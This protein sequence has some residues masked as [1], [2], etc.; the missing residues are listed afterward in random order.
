MCQDEEGTSMFVLLDGV[1]EVIK[2]GEKV[3]ELKADRSK[4][5]CP[6]IGEMA[7]LN[8]SPRSATVTVTSEKARAL[9][10]DRE[11]F[12]FLLGSLETILT[13]D[14]GAARE[15]LVGKFGSKN[16]V[17]LSNSIQRGVIRHEDLQSIGLLGCGHTG[18]V[19]LV[20]HKKTKETYALKGLSKGHMC[21]MGSQHRVINERDILLLAD[22]NFIIRCYE[23]YNSPQRL[24]F[25]LEP[26]M[27]GDLHTQYCSLGA[28]EFG[29]AYAAKYY[30]AAV[31]LAFEH[32]HQRKVIYRDL[33]LENLL[34][35][36]KGHLK[37]ADFD[38]SKIVAT[39]KTWTT[40]GT[41]DYF[42]PEMVQAKGHT[43][44][45]DWWTLG[46]LIFEL[47]CGSTPFEAD[48][49]L[50]IFENV[51]Q[52]IKKANFPPSCRG[53]SELVK[54]LLEANPIKRL[55]MRMN[56]VQ[57]LKAHKWY[58]SFNW[59]SMEALK[60]CPPF[61]PHIDDMR[62]LKHFCSDDMEMPPEVKYVD[63][64]TGWD[65]EFATC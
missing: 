12:N 18:S 59:A 1:V 61:I 20:E 33:K 50:Q 55:P 39:G 64:G 7:L 43:H 16:T 19:E 27:G 47:M 14:A 9:M 28:I 63:N 46:V 37:L 30:S 2:S 3:C 42:A 36:H 29:N 51:M 23:T 57:Q 5:L 8:K 56:G 35:N 6:A 38:L 15:S 10:I 32:L 21:Q 22:S 4:H 24:Y 58:G 52:G 62:D 49:E 53:V 60:L 17:S 54:A 44:A 25:L 65:A 48:S 45:V 40:C 34:L 31:T 11:S 26:A 13:F 41:P